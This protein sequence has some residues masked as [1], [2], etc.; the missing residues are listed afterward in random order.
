MNNTSGLTCKGEQSKK[1]LE[2]KCTEFTNQKFGS[3]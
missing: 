2:T 3:N 1:S